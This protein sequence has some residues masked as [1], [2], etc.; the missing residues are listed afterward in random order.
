M[1]VN[2]G[3]PSAFIIKPIA[4]PWMGCMTNTP[5]C[6]AMLAAINVRRATRKS[7]RRSSAS[8]PVATLVPAPLVIDAGDTFA[9]AA[10]S[11]SMNCSSRN[12][13]M[14]AAR[15]ALTSASAEGF[16]KRTSSSVRTTM[17]A[18]LAHLS[19]AVEKVILPSGLATPSPT[20]FAEPKP[21]V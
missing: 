14:A 4:R 20:Q 3:C 13:A 6:G 2:S 1:P 19:V 9:T 7:Q 5:P 17:P 8:T 10:T 15:S 16:E 18:T 11:G 21:C 12:C